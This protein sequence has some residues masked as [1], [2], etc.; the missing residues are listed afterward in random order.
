MNS[1]R[2]TLPH[3]HSFIYH[4]NEAGNQIGRSRHDVREQ[5]VEHL[6]G[7]SEEIVGRS[8]TNTRKE[9]VQHFDADGHPIGYSKL[10]DE[11]CVAEHFDMETNYIGESGFALENSSIFH[12]GV[13]DI[14]FFT[15]FASLKSLFHNSYPKL[16]LA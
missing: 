7:T 1:F 4:Y 13:S 10:N 6:K 14:R 3:Q 5:L 9:I 2:S 16:N 11:K 8:I 12:D 15:A